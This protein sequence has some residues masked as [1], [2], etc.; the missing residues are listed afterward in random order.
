MKLT[1]LTSGAVMAA[2]AFVL[3]ILP[4]SFPFPPIPYLKFDLAEVPVFIALLGFGPASGML[5]TVIYFMALL[6]MGE[7]S[8][9]GPTMKFLA[10]SSSLLGFW[11]GSRIVGSRGLGL[12]VGV[13]AVVGAIVR[14]VT[15][16]VANYVVLAIMF[17]EFLSFATTT[18]SAFLGLNL[19]A[20]IQ[21]LFLVLLFTAVFNALHMVLS[22]APSVLAINSIHKAK[23]F[24]TVWVP[25][26]IKIS[27]QK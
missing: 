26:V 6:I 17:P 1:P 16:T 15:M 7:F 9:I 18:L 19:A 14:V 11:I 23:A 10:V 20:D 27:K 3:A 8:P 5:A 24:A 21:G 22:V 4:L 12:I 2:F 13:G 25:W